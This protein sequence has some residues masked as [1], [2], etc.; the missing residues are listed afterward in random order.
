MKLVKLGAF[1]ACLLAL[2]AALAS[3]Q[4]P[5]QVCG[6]YRTGCVWEFV[7]CG[8]F[9]DHSWG[10]YIAASW[11]C[12]GSVPDNWSCQDGLNGGCC[13]IPHSIDCSQLYP[14]TC[15]CPTGN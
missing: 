1:C 11:T 4:D 8:G 12:T 3:A 10:T 7:D 13:T 15:P 9:F 6:D 14:G 2:W 5:P